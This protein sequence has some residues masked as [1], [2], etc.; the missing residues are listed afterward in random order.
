[1]HGYFW[2]SENVLLYFESSEYLQ[3]I[4]SPPPLPLFHQLSDQLDS[5]REQCHQLEGQLQKK[6]V[7][8]TASQGKIEVLTAETQAKVSCQQLHVTLPDSLLHL[9]HLI[10]V[11]SGAHMYFIAQEYLIHL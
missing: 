6:E 8:L 10:S 7:A 11:M 3:M 9:H 2:N 1:M 5:A 4:P